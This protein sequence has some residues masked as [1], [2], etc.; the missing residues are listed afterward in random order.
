MDIQLLFKQL[1]S[2]RAVAKQT[3][4]ARNTVRRMLRAQ[5]P[6]AFDKPERKTGVDDFKDYLTSRYAE[7]GLSAARLLEEIRPQGFAGSVHM[8]RRFIRKLRHRSRHR[9]L[10]LTPTPTAPTTSTDWA[11]GRRAIVKCRG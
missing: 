2:I 8:V 6:P 7:H 11:T 10:F 5:S 9:S 1:G 3:G 4:Y